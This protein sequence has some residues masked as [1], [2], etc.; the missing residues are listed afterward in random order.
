MQFHEM[1]DD[2]AA[3]ATQCRE[4]RPEN[5]DLPEPGILVEVFRLLA[6]IQGIHA[7][8]NETHEN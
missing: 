5:Y 7:G 2:A 3:E 1:A 6:R 8:R 4:G